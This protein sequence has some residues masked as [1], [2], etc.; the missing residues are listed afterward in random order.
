MTRIQN[1]PTAKFK[2][3]W[4]N[5]N[6]QHINTFNKLKDELS[7]DNVLTLPNFNETFNIHVDASDVAIGAVLHQ[8][9]G[10]VA[11]F[12]QKLTT[13]QKNYRAT[14]KEFLAL[15]ASVMRFKYYLSGV[16]F[17]IFSDHKPL[18]YL[19]KGK[20]NN[21]RQIRW[22]LALQEFD[23]STNYIKGVDNTA[24]DSLSRA[25]YENFHVQQI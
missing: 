15:Y 1:T 9:N 23:F 25:E 22:Q 8:T 21:G 24:A 4:N 19:I 6:S 10:P 2:K 16:R 13:A 14:D 12:S 3:V 20:A 11:F 5:N 17:R 18:E 7:S